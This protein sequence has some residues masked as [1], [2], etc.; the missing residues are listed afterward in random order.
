MSQEEKNAK[1][2]QQVRLKLGQWVN[3]PLSLAARILVTN[4]VIL[5]SI[6]LAKTKSMVRNYI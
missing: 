6:I 1:V 5:A 2:L 4:Q 3:K